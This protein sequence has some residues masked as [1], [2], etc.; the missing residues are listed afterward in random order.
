MC[1]WIEKED[2]LLSPG[3]A[4]RQQGKGLTTEGMKGMGNGEAMLTIYVIRC[5]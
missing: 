4:L 1:L 2:T 3:K 5:S